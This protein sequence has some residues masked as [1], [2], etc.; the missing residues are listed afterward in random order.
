MYDLDEKEREK[1]TI[2][3]INGYDDVVMA[4]SSEGSIYYLPAIS[5]NVPE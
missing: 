1:W 5:K 4:L 2:D 3:Q